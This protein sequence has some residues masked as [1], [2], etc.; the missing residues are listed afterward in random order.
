MIRV[1]GLR[2]VLRMA[3]TLW[4]GNIFDLSLVFQMIAITG[5]A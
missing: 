5:R 2:E 3:R 1:Q 4:Q